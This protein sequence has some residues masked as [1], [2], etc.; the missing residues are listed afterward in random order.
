LDVS[1]KE[2]DR[3]VAN[4][5]LVY[6][7]ARAGTVGNA[8]RR[9]AQI[10]QAIGSAAI[11]VAAAVVIPVAL[12]AVPYALTLNT[13][14]TT[15]TWAAAGIVWIRTAITAERAAVARASSAAV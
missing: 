5:E 9:V 8:S 12:T 3:D 15:G 14:L 6:V 1:S 13:E 10:R 4:T 11:R 7:A 2:T